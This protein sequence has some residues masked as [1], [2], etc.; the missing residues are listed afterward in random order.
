MAAGGPSSC[1]AGSRD[2]GSSEG[3]EGL[4]DEGGT[5]GVQISP[6]TAGT[7]GQPEDMVLER[8]SMVGYLNLQELIQCKI[9]QHF[10]FLY[11]HS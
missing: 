9:L 6:N 4:G 1:V 8:G 3:A 2:E 7:G 10:Y 5:N 11:K